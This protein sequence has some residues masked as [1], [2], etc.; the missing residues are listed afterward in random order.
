M[1]VRPL[2]PTFSHNMIEWSLAKF[3][4]T[5]I[6]EYPGLLATAVGGLPGQSLAGGKPGK[7]NWGDFCGLDGGE[8]GGGGLYPSYFRT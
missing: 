6:T 3:K 1:I 4:H 2:P 8:G 7:K 5:T